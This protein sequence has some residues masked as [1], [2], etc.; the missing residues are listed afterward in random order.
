[1]KRD[2]RASLGLFQRLLADAVL[3]SD[4]VASVAALARNRRLP[5]SLRRLVPKISPDGVRI[6]A[7]LVTKLRFERLV[8]GD[9]RIRGWFEEAPRA[10]VSLFRRYH[11]EVP[12]TFLFP[13]A[14]AE[15]FGRWLAKGE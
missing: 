11:S 1:M 10:F 2:C 6:S 12:P 8:N 14:E 13:R 3:S 4:P 9:A 5:A 7:L 15:A